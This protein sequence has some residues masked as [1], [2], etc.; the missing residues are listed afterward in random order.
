MFNLL[1]PCRRDASCIPFRI[2]GVP[3]RP[4]AE[5]RRRTS[6]ATASSGATSPGGGGLFWGGRGG[7]SPRW[8]SLAPTC[9]APSSP[10]AGT[11][12]ESP[13]ATGGLTGTSSS[14][15]SPVRRRSVTLF[16]HLWRRT[17]FYGEYE[18]F[19]PGARLAGRVSWSRSLSADEV[20]PF[21]NISM[22]D[23]EAWLSPPP[24]HFRNSSVGAAEG[25]IPPGAH[26]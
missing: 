8:C 17:V 15:L 22:I 26:A 16:P 11:T 18:C 23:G 10:A 24:T 5:A 25:P 12:G 21:L 2:T 19:G 9:P 4:S 7:T 14:F 1:S 6:R 3:S 20:A 13:A